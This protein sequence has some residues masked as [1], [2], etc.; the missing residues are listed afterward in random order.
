MWICRKYYYGYEPLSVQNGCLCPDMSIFVDTQKNGK[1]RVR[2]FDG[3]C[4]KPF[5]VEKFSDKSLA[6][7]FVEEFI[8]KHKFA[9]LEKVGI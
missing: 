1:C 4:G 2:M 5:R 3:A 8:A 9:K 7:N 6:D